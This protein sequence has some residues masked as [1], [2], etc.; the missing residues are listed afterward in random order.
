V[1]PPGPTAADPFSPDAS[2][3]LK[4]DTDGDAVADLPP[5]KH[6]KSDWSVENCES[7]KLSLASTYQEAKNMAHVN[8][9]ALITGSN[10]GIGF[11]TARQ[12]G[13]QGVTVVVT[14]RTGKEAADTARKLR[15]EGIDASGVTLDVTRA[16]DRIAVARHI[17]SHFG[18]L[19]IL[20]NNAGIGPSDGLIGKRTSESSQEELQNVFNVNLFSLVAVTRE[21][22]PLLKRS[23]AGRIVNLASILGSLTLH[24]AEPSPLAQ[25]RKFAYNASKAAVNIFT[26]HL[27][28]ELEGTNI[29]V[30]SVHPG[31]VKTELGSDAAPTSIPDGAKTSVA[32]ALLG[33]NGPNGR[34]IQN[35]NQELPW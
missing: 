32:V 30:N 12:L 4:I 11:E 35:T 15:E 6:Q 21:L 14:G 16:E 20:V 34:F 29:K 2:Y 10:R 8:K 23:D 24:A 28:G 31:W 17:E 3:E 9:V 1:N 5:R 18:K 33:S 13:Q 26:I 22:L 7:L 27:A 19:D 25:M